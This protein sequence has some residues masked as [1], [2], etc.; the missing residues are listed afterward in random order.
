MVLQN[1]EPGSLKLILQTYLL[2]YLAKQDENMISQW[3]SFFSIQP[4]LTSSLLIFL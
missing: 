1:S 3:F 4:F 2:E